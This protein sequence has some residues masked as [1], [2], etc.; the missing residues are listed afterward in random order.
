MLSKSD[1]G[2]TYVVTGMDLPEMIQRRLEALGLTL[3]TPL[4]V[5]SSKGKGILI[6]KFRGTRFA[7]GNRISE[8]IEVE[9]VR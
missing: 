6:V 3:G 7:L 8:K 2:K 1:V 9:A 4:T 5:L